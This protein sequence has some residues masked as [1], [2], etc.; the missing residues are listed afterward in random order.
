M[1]LA[2]L[3]L[4]SSLLDARLTG[5]RRALHDLV[6]TLVILWLL[7]F[8][9][10]YLMPDKLEDA[11]FI[12]NLVF[13]IYFVVE[14]LIRITGQGLDMY[15]SGGMNWCVLTGSQC[16]SHYFCVGAPDPH[17]WPGNRFSQVACNGAYHLA[18]THNACDVV[19]TL[20]QTMLLGL[21][22]KQCCWTSA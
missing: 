16:Q 20:H 12:M 18:C 17:H 9:P 22:I 2:L 4:L 6:F 7:L 1:H 14:F 3:L 10:R 13:T 11:M 5:G 15:F 21:C 8:S 19:G